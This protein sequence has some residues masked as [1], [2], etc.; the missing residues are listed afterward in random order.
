MKDV[1]GGPFLS[2]LVGSSVS[3]YRI[4]EKLGAGGMGEVFKA[5]DVKLGRKVALKFL[6]ETLSDDPGALERFEREARAASAI[7]HPNICTIYE[8]GEHDGRPF[9]AMELVEGRTLAEKLKSGPMA[10]EEA[11]RIARQMAEALEEAHEHDII[12]RDLK[13]ANVIV[14]AKG[15]AKILDFGLAKL[16]RPISPDAPTAEESLLTRA[17]A[18]MGT[19]PYMA[20]EQLKGEP[21]D[22]RTDLYALGELLF[23]MVTGRRPFTETQTAQL[24]AAILSQPPPPLRPLNKEIPPELE[25]IILKLLAKHPS[26]RYQ[27]AHE[28]LTDLGPASTVTGLPLTARSLTAARRA[29]SR[30]VAWVVGAAVLCAIMAALVFLAWPALRHRQGAAPATEKGL[31]AQKELAVLPFSV[32]GGKAGD[33]AF[34][35]GL[36]ETLAA[37]LAQLSPGHSLQVVP[38][39]DVYAHHVAT[40]R[41]AQKEFGVNLVISGSLERAGDRVRI[42]C[43]LV[44]PSTERQLTAS[45]I[46]QAASDPFGIEDKVVEGAA[47]MLGLSLEPADRQAV[48][49]HGTQDARAFQDYL[50]GLG[51]LQNYEKIE[52]LDKAIG[53]FQSALNVDPAYALAYAGLGEAYWRKYEGTGD[54]AWVDHARESC[55]RAV[56]LDSKLPASH[57]CLGTLGNGTGQYEKAAAEFRRVIE[58]EPTN[59]RAY[60]G[61]ASAQYHLGKTA[62]AE[63]T[64]L[65]AISIEPNYWGPYIWL[66][67][68]YWNTGQYPKAAG[69]F[70]KVIELA[71][72]NYNGYDNLGAVYYFQGRWA[73]AE[74]MF[75]KSISIHRSATGYSNLGTV[76]FFQGHYAEAARMFEKATE[77]TPKAEYLWGNLADAYRWAPGEHDKAAA[78]YAKAIGLVEGDLQVNPKSAE[79]WS[80]LALYRAKTS[81][82][83][84]AIQAIQKAAQF[85]PNDVTVTYYTALVYHLAGDQAQ[86]LV[87]LKRA[88]AKGYSLHE[89]RAD[90][91]WNGLKNDPAFQKLVASRKS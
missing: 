8:I 35:R 18:V 44:D 26:G 20:P 16:L 1:P 4:S 59:T 74:G 90:P 87:W 70:K 28:L 29:R 68:L 49:T 88:I 79:S 47:T 25:A 72:E 81:Q 33:D 60:G 41:D 31:P 15:R 42:T 48:E 22:A 13:P 91:E 30:K 40:A 37:K 17:G 32:I 45:T 62:D 73:D 38:A 43:A 46:T 9:I 63:Q 36:S 10:I 12:H 53:T 24:I 2:E 57:L 75:Q 56:T 34:S 23:E 51:Y 76:I 5:E 78:A 55:D 61:L 71:P 65:R 58:S 66:G 64:Y 7:G 82:Q 80:H 27:S 11:L 19:V 86:A 50:Q 69:M 54:T 67:N 21:A 52:N 77:M 83:Q 6:P 14:T 39:G 85:G 3:H 84:A 89:I